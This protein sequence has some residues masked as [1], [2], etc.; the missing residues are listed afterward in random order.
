MMSVD[1]P[2]MVDAAASACRP[3]IGIVSIRMHFG[4]LPECENDKADQE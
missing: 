2:T 3:I 4:A 1:A